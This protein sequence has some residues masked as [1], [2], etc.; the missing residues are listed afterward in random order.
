VVI[1]SIGGRIGGGAQ[2]TFLGK[3]LLAAF[4]RIQSSMA[5]ATAADLK[6]LVGLTKAR[7][8]TKALKTRVK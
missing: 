7:K 2:L 4:R 5:R 3:N 1:T 8:R 6:F